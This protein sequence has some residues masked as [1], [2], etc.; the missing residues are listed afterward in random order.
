MLVCVG[1]GR[2]SFSDRPIAEFKIYLCLFVRKIAAGV[3]INLA[4]LAIFIKRFGLY[5]DCCLLSTFSC[6]DVLD[7][8]HIMPRLN[9]KATLEALFKERGIIVLNPLARRR[10][11]PEGDFEKLRYRFLGR[12]PSSDTEHEVRDIAYGLRIWFSIVIRPR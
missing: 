11:I 10:Q 1:L 5:K 8:P 4:A 9:I 6:H 2:L 3:K 7:S 12:F